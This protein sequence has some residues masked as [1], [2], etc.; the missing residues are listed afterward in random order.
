MK[1]HAAIGARLRA[2]R[3][4]RGMTLK[5]LA[6]HMGVTSSLLSQIETDKVQPSLNTLLQLAIRLDL[7]IDELLGIGRRKTDE[8]DPWVIVQRMADNP[9]L[10][11]SGGVRWERL[12]GR[13]G[14]GLEPL[15]VTYAPG[16]ASSADRAMLAT[17][18]FEFGV[19]SSG[20]LTLRIG[21]ETYSLNA[22]DSVFFDRS[23][24]HVYLN[25]SDEEARGVWF[26]VRAQ[27][28]LEAPSEVGPATSIS[29]LVDVLRVLD[30]QE[31]W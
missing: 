1:T 13:L 10:D 29:S 14:I 21:F 31:D 30:A 4:D 9:S 24:P 16:S 28:P 7:S 25:D 15:Q 12:A 8:E 22:G 3:E 20:T 11:M 26:V 18:G 23:R 5:T 6:D 2:A 19:L 27:E 17:A